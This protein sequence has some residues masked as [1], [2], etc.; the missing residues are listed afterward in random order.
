MDIG[1]PA[2]KSVPATPRISA[3]RNQHTPAPTTPRKPAP[4]SQHTPAP[5]TPNNFKISMEIPLEFAQSS[6]ISWTMTPFNS[7]TRTGDD[8]H[9]PERSPVRPR[10]ISTL[11]FDSSPFN[12]RASRSDID[13]AIQVETSDVAPAT[14]PPEQPRRTLEAE[15]ATLSPGQRRSRSRAVSP[16]PQPN[17]LFPRSSH[18]ASVLSASPALVVQASSSA[19]GASG[20]AGASHR[21]TGTFGQNIELPI[22]DNEIHEFDL[23]WAMPIYPIQPNQQMCE[24]LPNIPVQPKRYYTITK[25]IRLGV[26]YDEW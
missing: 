23:S 1:S 13:G 26:F 3:P 22:F 5:T 4:Q 24:R 10:R 6:Q 7:P 18:R 8:P 12:Q 2:P 9:T 21:V 25:G 16:S 15:P 11:C 17:F 19:P 20:Q 14:P